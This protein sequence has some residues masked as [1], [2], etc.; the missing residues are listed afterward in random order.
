M[1]NNSQ[2]PALPPAFAE[3][4]RDRIFETMKEFITDEHLAAMVKM[5][6]DAF[7]QHEKLFTVEVKEIQIPN[8]NHLKNGAYE[9]WKATI[10]QQVLALN[11][12]MTPFRQMVWHEVHEAV[13]PKVKGFLN[14]NTNEI[15]QALT[16]FLDDVAKPKTVETSH[17]LISSL[18]V[19][20][21][22]AQTHGMLTNAVQAA[23]QNM[24][25]SLMASGY[26]GYL[27]Q[28]PM[29]QNIDEWTTP[30]YRQPPKKSEG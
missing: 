30:F 19:G 1:S 16:E 4:V 23:H 9:S 2:L 27:P 29:M 5:E 14:D 10:P 15:N 8:P 7:F 24:A 22:A 17:S 13:Q 6:I 25:S 11:I 18:A 3:K 28:V 12:R 20:M 26:T 21:A